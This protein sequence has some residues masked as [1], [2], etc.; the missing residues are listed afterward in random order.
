MIEICITICIVA[1]LVC[2]TIAFVFYEYYLSKFDS[3]DSSKLE[4]VNTICDYILEQEELQKE[5]DQYFNPYDF[6]TAVEEI[7]NITKMYKQ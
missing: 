1:L 6:R 3:G 7:Y 5:A 2:A 4:D